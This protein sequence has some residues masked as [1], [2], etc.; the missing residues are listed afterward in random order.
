MAPNG[1]LRFLRLG[2]LLVTLLA[3]PA[4]LRGEISAPPLAVPIPRSVKAEVKRG[5]SV[6]LTLGIYGREGESVTFRIQ[7]Q[8]RYGQISEPKMVSSTAAVITYR[9]S[10]DFTHLRDAFTYEAK[11]SEGVSA[12]ATVEITVTDDPPIFAMPD[13]I[14]FGEMVIGS[15]AK[16]E[17]ELENQGSG[18]IDGVMDVD[19]MWKI[20]PKENYHLGPGEKQLFVIEFS[21]QTDGEFRG[22]IHYSDYPDRETS[23]HASVKPPFSVLPEV[24]ELRNAR[25]DPVRTG[26]FEVTNETDEPEKVE[27]TLPSH[28]Q[29]PKEIELAAAEKK[30]VT[31][32]TS[33]EYVEPLEGSA[34]L[35]VPAWKKTLTVRG[36]VVGPILR[37]TPEA[38]SFGE[39]TVGNDLTTN[40]T[41]KNGGGYQAIVAVSIPPPFQIAEEDA[42]FPL[43]P[44]AEKS[45]PVTFAARDTGDFNDWIRIE[46]AE[47]DLS[48]RVQARVAP[49]PVSTNVPLATLMAAGGSVSGNGQPAA[50][51]KVSDVPAISRIF[52]RKVQATTCEMSWK[53]PARGE[54]R[55]EIES[56][57][58]SLDSQ[59]NLQVDWVPFTNFS[60]TTVGNEIRARLSGLPPQYPCAIRIRSIDSNG[61]VSAS[62]RPVYFATKPKWHP[63]ITFLE[64]LFAA[65]AVMLG[66]IIR[67][68]FFA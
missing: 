48:I 8:P 23:L 58:L 33:P 34:V 42:S 50:K 64:V 52:L 67:Q 63:K 2:A 29:G 37:T 36:A 40:L 66:V 68:R 22:E 24:V 15:T 13:K 53:P 60:T 25:G 57:R 9:N 17:I 7:T 41:V 1:A 39:T 10:G 16:K 38:I 14:D 26:S 44:G 59:K 32:K 27:I 51:P 55:Y 46:A 56:R 49:G 18:I 3:G 21:A 47:N 35:S 45:I 4:L 5:G 28:V 30:T 43:G 61:E 31:V 19:K 20:E 65:L 12:P 6:E 11:T 62:S 54:L